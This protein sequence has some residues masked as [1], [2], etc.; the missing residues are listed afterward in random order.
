MRLQKSRPLALAA[1]MTLALPLVAQTPTAT[2]PAPKHEDTEVYTP[3]PPVVT[4]GTTNEAPPSD[5]IVLFDGK[6][7]D[8]WVSS[9]DHSPA[10]W[11]V[12]NGTLTVNKTNGSGT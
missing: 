11:D 2:G 5:A 8:E 1:L 9:K 10:K 3:V 4:P 12:A 6:N 7:Q